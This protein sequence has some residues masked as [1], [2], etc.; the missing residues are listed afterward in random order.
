MKNAYFNEVVKKLDPYYTII[1]LLLVFVVIITG[2]SFIFKEGKEINVFI[3]FLCGIAGILIFVYRKRTSFFLRMFITTGIMYLFT[4]QSLAR[5]GFVGNGILALTIIIVLGVAFFPSRVGIIYCGVMTGTL[6]VYTVLYGLKVLGLGKIQPERYVDA[7][8]WIYQT[9]AL[10][11]FSI[12]TYVAINKI[13][14]LLLESLKRLEKFAYNDVLTGINNRNYFVDVLPK[15][16]DETRDKNCIIAAVDILNFKMINTV[17]GISSGDE[18]LKKVAST[19]SDLIPDNSYIARIG[20]NEFAFVSCDVDKEEFIEYVNKI[21]DILDR[22]RGIINIPRQRYIVAYTEFNSSGAEYIKAFSNIAIALKYGKEHNYSGIIQFKQE[23]Y[24]YYSNEQELSSKIKE[25]LDNDQFYMNYQGK[26]DIEN[27]RFMGFEALARWTLEDGRNISPGV[28]IPL[29]SKSQYIDEFTEYTIYRSLDEYMVFKKRFDNDITISINIS[30]LYFIRDYFEDIIKEAVKSREIDPK[31]VY[32][33][34]TEDIF[35]NDYKIISEKA[36]R[37]RKSGFK[38]SL[39]DFGAGYSSMRHICNIE[40]DEIKIDKSISDSIKDSEKSENLIGTIVNMAKNLN[41]NV[42][43]E[44]IE[45][46][47]QLTKV[48]NTGCKIVQGY[49]FSRPEPIDKIYQNK[50]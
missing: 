6:G 45:D 35:I 27:K 22:D 32:L 10:L 49:Y 29:V 42:V 38:I 26:Y 20:S 50:L 4:L 19:M 44:G 40:F 7:S 16:I 47:N 48:E 34:I 24:D 2:I 28:F 30:P 5:N 46:E 13:R 39:D 43:I 1:N 11:L 17:Y 15:K 31:N 33:E 37:L 14:S 21:V 41:Y 18:L 9:V 23:M 36:A 25:G 12:I 8:E 3:N